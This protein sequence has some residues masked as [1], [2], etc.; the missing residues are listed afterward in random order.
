MNKLFLLFFTLVISSFSHAGTAIFSCVNC[1]DQVKISIGA[2]NSMWPIELSFVFLGFFLLYL[3]YFIFKAIKKEKI[4]VKEYACLGFFSFI[5]LFLL[6]FHHVEYVENNTRIDAFM[7][8]YPKNSPQI[9]ENFSFVGVYLY[10]KEKDTFIIESNENH[11]IVDFKKKQ[12]EK[13]N[14]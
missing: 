4:E 6:V 9:K 12:V 14:N 5:F 2:S 8:K 1:S 11:Y 13:I 7:K 3:G 10:N